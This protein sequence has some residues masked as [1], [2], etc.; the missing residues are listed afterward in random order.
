[1]RCRVA[2]WAATP[3][4]RA[5]AR[6]AGWS[7]AAEPDLLEAICDPAWPAEIRRVREALFARIAPAH[8]FALARADGRPAASGL[9]VADGELAG[10]FS[11][12]TQPG[13]RRRG[14][15][16]SVLLRL[17][18]WARSLGARRVYLQVKDDNAGALRLYR[19]FGFAKV[20]GYHYR[21]RGLS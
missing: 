21:E 2:A 4:S 12:R 7:A 15:A 20:Y 11:M 6:R 5:A 13:F 18:G 10:V 19:R 8:R 14:L 3:R 16:E 17:A 9:C 1:V